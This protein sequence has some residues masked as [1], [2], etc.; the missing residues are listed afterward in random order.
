MRN[1]IEAYKL[2]GKSGLR[3]MQDSEEAPPAAEPTEPCI[4]IEELFARMEQ[5]IADT[6]RAISNRC[7]YP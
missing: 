4:K 6:H 3:I 5:A 2:P 1:E 7:Q